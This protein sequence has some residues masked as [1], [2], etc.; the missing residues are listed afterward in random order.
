MIKVTNA[1]RNT[2]Y[3]YT[4]QAKLEF[5]GASFN[6]CQESGILMVYEHGETADTDK[7]SAVFSDG[8]WVYAIFGPAAGQR[9]RPPPAN[10]GETG[11]RGIG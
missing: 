6:V 5:H 4:H 9:S 7:L 3:V 11:L 1:S 10:K 8:S 2:L